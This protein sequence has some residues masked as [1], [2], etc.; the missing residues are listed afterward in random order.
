MLDSKVCI[1][2]NYKKELQQFI[3]GELIMLKLKQL[4]LKS[5]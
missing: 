2:L 1:K 5:T 4:Q 3:N